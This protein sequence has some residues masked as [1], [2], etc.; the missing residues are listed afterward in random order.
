M[1]SHGSM[2][3]TQLVWSRVSGEPKGTGNYPS[4]LLNIKSF[5]DGN[6]TQ[7]EEEREKERGNRQ[8][9]KDDKWMDN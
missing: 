3:Q 9:R 7:I 5:R 6:A 4:P 1:K 2:L 8:K